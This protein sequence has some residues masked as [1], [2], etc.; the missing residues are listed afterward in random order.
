VYAGSRVDGFVQAIDPTIN[1]RRKQ[2]L[3]QFWT[4][5]IGRQQALKIDDEVFNLRYARDEPF[6]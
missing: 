4:D 3:R 1:V 6:I 5:D 2:R